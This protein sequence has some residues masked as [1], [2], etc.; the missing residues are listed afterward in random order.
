MKENQWKEY[1]KQMWCDHYSDIVHF[2]NI[3]NEADFQ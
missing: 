3:E 1:Y 2:V